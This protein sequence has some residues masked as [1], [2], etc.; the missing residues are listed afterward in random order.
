MV[1]VYR[2]GVQETPIQPGR[3]IQ[4]APVSAF[5]AG[6]A[7]DISKIGQ[8]ITNLGAAAYRSE[9]NTEG[10]KHRAVAREGLNSARS[11]LR[12]F[13][14]ELYQRKGKDAVDAYKTA[15]DKHNELRSRYTE[16]MTPEQRDMFTASYDNEMQ[17]SLDRAIKFQ[18][19]ARLDFDHSTMDAENQN[20][21]EDAVD[22]IEDP[23]ELVEAKSTIIANTRA[24]LIGQDPK[25]VAKGVED[26]VH[27][28]H[29]EVL[30]AQPLEERLGYLKTHWKEVNPKVREGLKSDIEGMMEQTWVRDKAMELS[31]SGKSLEQQLA[32]ADK[33]ADAGKAEKTKKLVKDRYNEKQSLKNLAVKEKYESEV[34]LIFKDPLK[35]EGVPPTFPAQQQEHLYNLHQKL[36]SE[37]LAKKGVG[38]KVQTNWGTYDRL[39]KMPRDQFLKE[40]MTKYQAELAGSEM[41][42]LIQMQA[43]DKSYRNAQGLN[44]YINQMVKDTGE[45]NFAQQSF[46]REM[47]ENELNAY[48]ADKR[49][50]M[51]TWNKIKDTMFMEVDVKGSIFDSSYWEARQ[52]GQT[53]VEPDERP[54]G[55]PNGASWADKTNKDGKVYRG[56]EH[57]NP[58]GVKVL[59]G[60]DG[61]IYRAD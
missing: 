4:R 20:A 47:F 51:E 31:S 22:S 5:G 32:E 38:A 18:E 11:E 42:Q 19:K 46:I 58:Q 28:L 14:A 30:K 6:Q 27:D 8:A 50:T 23:N 25:V 39:L 61:K 24:K 2:R 53:V 21:I 57:I 12:Q 34:D 26:A 36:K 48:P 43:D 16:G 35:Y 33:I 55:I 13:N 17:R 59:Y 49:N 1:K 44:S 45:E 41:K 10:T 7:A 56:W 37:E 29:M 54:E 60:T 3:R 52:K 40:D 9:K 15:E